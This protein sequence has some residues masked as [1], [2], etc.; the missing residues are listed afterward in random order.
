MRRYTV[1][2]GLLILLA[3]AVA[4]VL[5]RGIGEAERKPNVQPSHGAQI[6]NTMPIDRVNAEKLIPP[7][8]PS[9]E[10]KRPEPK[11]SVSATTLTPLTATVSDY[12]LL[13][14]DTK[15]VA[16]KAQYEAATA[17]LR[18]KRLGPGEG[19]KY[20]QY[21]VE[22]LSVFK[23]TSGTVI[24][25]KHVVFVIGSDNTDF[26]ASECTVY[27]E[28]NANKGLAPC[29]LLNGTVA[30]GMSHPNEEKPRE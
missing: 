13:P 12:D 1:A 16:N 30:Q 9:D 23:N 24:P 28:P 25:S 6:E 8:S 21:S 27:L 20:T 11:P 14:E 4:L 5:W 2:A 7:E 26:P 19:S 29:K 18:V 3:I 15:K 22:V 17:V 10:T